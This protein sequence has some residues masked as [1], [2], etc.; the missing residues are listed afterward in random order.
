[1]VSLDHDIVAIS[2]GGLKD[3]TPQSALIAR[4]SQIDEKKFVIVEATAKW[5]NV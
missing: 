1:M 4:V 2:G 3:S 5:K